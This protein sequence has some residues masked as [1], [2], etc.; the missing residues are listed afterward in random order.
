MPTGAKTS[1]LLCSKQTVRQVLEALELS[2]PRTH[3]LTA[4]VDLLPEGCASEALVDDAIRLSDYGVKPRYPVPSF[5]ATADQANAAIAAAERVL[6]WADAQ[7]R[8][9]RGD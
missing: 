6:D 9:G 7:W 8:V 5:V 2:I 3:D 4:L 1:L